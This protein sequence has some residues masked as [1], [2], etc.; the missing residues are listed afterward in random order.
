MGFWPT[1]Y[2]SVTGYLLD[3]TLDPLT[4]PVNFRNTGRMPTQ[5]WPGWG[6]Y[7]P[8]GKEYVPANTSYETHFSGTP[9]NIDPWKNF[10]LDPIIFSGVHFDIT[11]PDTSEYTVMGLRMALSI[12]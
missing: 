4:A 9:I 3:A 6:Y 12:F 11:Y 7:L 5:I 10:F 8:D 1:S 2:F